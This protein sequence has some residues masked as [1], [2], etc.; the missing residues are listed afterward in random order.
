MFFFV[1]AVVFVV[2]RGALCPPKIPEDHASIIPESASVPDCT[3]RARKLT[4]TS[5]RTA[6][7][8][9]GITVVSTEEDG[10]TVAGASYWTGGAT[11]GDADAAVAAPWQ[12]TLGT[13]GGGGG[14]VVGSNVGGNIGGNGV[15]GN[16]IGNGGGELDPVAAWGRKL[17]AAPGNHHRNAAAAGLMFG[18]HHHHQQ[19]T[20]SPGGLSGLHH[21][22]HHHHHH[23]VRGPVTGLKEEPLTNS[24]LSVPRSWMQPSIIDQSKLVIVF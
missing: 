14:G 16:G 10:R 21:H 23:Q 5:Y 12:S 7:G 20:G 1:A 24:Q 19:D 13:L 17:Y 3:H 11:G 22:H 15:G 18:L 6:V 4:D 8:P 2:S 9:D